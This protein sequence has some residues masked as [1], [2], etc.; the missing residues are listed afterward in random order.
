M[1]IAIYT[2]KKL[3]TILALIIMS[4]SGFAADVDVKHARVRAVQDGQLNSAA[5]K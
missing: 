5:L 4:S 3:L 1:K 2:Y